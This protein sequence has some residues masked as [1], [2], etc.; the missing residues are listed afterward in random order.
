MTARIS[1]IFAILVHLTHAVPLQ[2]PTT[3]ATVSTPCYPQP[4]THD[5]LIVSQSI[6]KIFVKFKNLSRK[7]LDLYEVD[8]SAPGQRQP[9]GRRKLR[10]LG[11]LVSGDMSSMALVNMSQLVT[12]VAGTEEV[13]DTFAISS[14]VSFYGLGQ[15]LGRSADC[16]SDILCPKLLQEFEEESIYVENYRKKHGQ[17][18]RSHY[19]FFEP[20][21]GPRRPPSIA[22]SFWP[23]DRQGQVHRC[24]SQEGHWVSN[25]RQE[26]TDT[27]LE[28]EL[29]CIS[30]SP[31]CFVIRNFLSYFEA[32]ELI[33]LG[34]TVGNLQESTVGSAALGGNMRNAGQRSSSNAWLRPHDSPVVRSVYARAADLLQIDRGVMEQA[35][36]PM[37]L[38]HYKVGQQYQSHYDWEVRASVPS[39]RFATLLLYLNDQASGTAGGETAFPQAVMADGSTG[40]KIHPGKGNAVLFYNLLE[41]GNGDAISLH[42]AL[43]VAEGEK[44]ASN[45]WVWG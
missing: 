37:Q 33:R 9:K 43:P 27:E 24:L 32:D 38:V 2:R 5:D 41:D 14:A 42:S 29:E 10:I 36:E 15:G 7:R 44:W 34:K 18:W 16:P 3:K 1:L 19:G 35:T 30:T 12:K 8:D 23:A 25:N 40:F 28:L 21:L 20:N 6:D 31:R 22:R 26:T 4:V 45:L 39:N 11:S 13:L 17:P